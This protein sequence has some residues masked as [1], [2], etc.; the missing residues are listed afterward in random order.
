MNWLGDPRVTLVSDDG[1]HYI[2]H[3]LVLG[4]DDKNIRQI[5]SFESMKEFVLIFQ[6]TNHL[7]LKEFINTAYSSF[8]KI[9]KGRNNINSYDKITEKNKKRNTGINKLKDNIINHEIDIEE[10]ENDDYFSDL[11]AVEQDF[12]PH[13]EQK[14]RF[15]SHDQNKDQ[16]KMKIKKDPQKY[17]K[18][19]LQLNSEFG[20]QIKEG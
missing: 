17:P 19:G 11:K 12:D 1:C 14:G 13:I 15:L 16:E 8:E 20:I 7:E 18:S 2:C 3:A 6:Q 9:M 5:L 10:R 4:I